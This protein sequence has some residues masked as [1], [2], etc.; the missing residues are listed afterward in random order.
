[1]CP[2]VRR[3]GFITGP[4]LRKPRSPTGAALSLSQRL[5]VYLA[6]PLSLCYERVNLV[7]GHVPFSFFCLSPARSLFLSLSLSRSLSLAL[8]L[9]LV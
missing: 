1:M 6:L 7:L 9:I 5:S 8:S 3:A 2:S 4:S